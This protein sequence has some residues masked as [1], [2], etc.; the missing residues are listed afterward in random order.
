M[1]KDT[2]LY[3]RLNIN[4]NS[5][6]SEIKKSYRKLSLKWHPDKNN[7]NKEEATKNFRKF[8]KHIL[9]Y[10]IQKKKSL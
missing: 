3:D 1:A 2:I 7:D 4:S 8:L 6:Q 5:T 9:Y 10:Q